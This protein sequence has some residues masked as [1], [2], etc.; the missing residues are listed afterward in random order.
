MI[1]RL[2]KNCYK[3]DFRRIEDRNAQQNLNIVRKIALNTIKVYK[4]KTVS[5]RPISK[6]MLDCLLEPENILI[7]L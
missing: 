2:H 4:T 5:K 6:I 7:R 3:F 1:Y